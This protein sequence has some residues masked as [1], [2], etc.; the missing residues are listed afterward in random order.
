M[1]VVKDLSVHFVSRDSKQADQT[2]AAG[3]VESQ[4]SQYVNACVWRLNGCM[5]NFEHDVWLFQPYRAF[6]TLN[7]HSRCLLRDHWYSDC[8]LAGQVKTVHF[9]L[10]GIY[11]HQ[12][13][14]GKKD[15]EFPEE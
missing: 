15:W 3:S 6:A 8:L 12:I 7:F 2:T 5:V 13:Q 11:F 1:P 9:V 14:Q 4:G 10:K